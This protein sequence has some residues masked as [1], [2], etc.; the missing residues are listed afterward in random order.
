MNRVALRRTRAVAGAAAR[1]AE[2]ATVGRAAAHDP[3]WPGVCTALAGL[4]EQRR[5]AVRIVDAD[6]GDGRLL[7]AAVRHARALGFTAIEGRG[8]DGS[9][10][11]VGR[12]RT[13]A[14]RL[15]DPAIGVTF[16]MADASV[17]LTE[18]FDLPADI[19]LWHGSRPGDLNAGIAAA[20]SRAGDRVI[21]DCP[22]ATGESRP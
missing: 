21:C 19:V 3:R 14:A 16:D 12:A 22:V 6:C 9:P 13:T 15:A 2:P 20:L 17:A 11:L 8:I 1:T 10:A 4:R 5:R 18:E 7:L